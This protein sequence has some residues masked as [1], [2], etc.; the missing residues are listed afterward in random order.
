MASDFLQKLFLAVPI[1]LCSFIAAHAQDQS[2][3]AWATDLGSRY[4][5][6]P[7]IVYQG[8]SWTSLRL[9]TGMALPTSMT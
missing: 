4:W 9:L 7:D 2:S 6:Q 1:I 8:K 5:I 3:S